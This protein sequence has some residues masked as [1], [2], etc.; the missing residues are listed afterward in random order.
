[1]SASDAI[2]E[3]FEGIQ[4]LDLAIFMA[5]HDAMQRYHRSKLGILWITASTA[6]YIGGIGLVFGS[7]LNVPTDQLIPFLAIGL[8]LWNF[9]AANIN[10]G[11][12]AFINSSQ[13]ILQVRMPLFTH[14]LRKFFHNLIVLFYCLILLPPILIIY[15]S[16]IGWVILLVI[17]GFVVMT[18]NLLFIMLISA[19]ICARFRDITLIVQNALQLAFFMT[20]IMWMPEHL[21]EN[22]VWLLSYNPFAHLLSIVRDP[23]LGKFPTLS[24]WQFSMALLFVTGLMAIFMLSR[25]RKIIAYWL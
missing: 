7:I 9:L 14:I 12:I 25:F 1:M 11:C 10:D 17:P 18:L 20:P 21:P 6:I 2:K 15:K 4:K 5:K 8:I 19:I 22:S 13:I 3:V 24:S 23:L 16:Q